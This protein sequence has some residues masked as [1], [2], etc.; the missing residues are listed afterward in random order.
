MPFGLTRT[1][2]NAPEAL[3]DNLAGNGWNIAQWP[4]LT[5]AG[6]TIIATVGDSTLYVDRCQGAY[7]ARFGSLEQLVPNEDGGYTLIDTSG[8]HIFFNGFSESQ[9]YLARGRFVGITNAAG[10]LSDEVFD[11]PDGRIASITHGACTI[12]YEYEDDSVDPPLVGKLRQVTWSDPSGAVRT[13]FYIYYTQDDGHLA[14]DTFV[15]N[16]G[17]LK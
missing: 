2:T 8:N 4:K 13:V 12:T 3:S 15:G 16:P 14:D 17:D 9:P 5:Q 11:K 6:D 7:Y 1:W 10:M